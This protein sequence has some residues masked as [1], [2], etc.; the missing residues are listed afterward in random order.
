MS[1][2]VLIIS[3][4]CPS[5]DN[6][7]NGNFEFDQARALTAVGYEVIMLCVDR[8]RSAVNRKIGITVEN[9]DGILV[10]KI[11][12][13]PLPIR[14]FL[15]LTTLF[16]LIIGYFL[17]VRIKKDIGIPDIV[18]SHYLYNHPLAVLIGKKYNI[19]TILTEHW[20]VLNFAH[21]PFSVKFI[22]LKTYPY[23]SA[24]VAVSESLRNSIY[25]ISSVDSVVINNMVDVDYFSD[26]KISLPKDEDKFIFISVGSL[27]PV[28][29]YKLLIESFVDA[30]FSKDVYLYIVGYGIDY[31]NLLSIIK[32]YNI[33]NRVLLL[34]KKNRNEIRNLLLAADVFVLSSNSE[35]FGVVLIEAMACGLPVIS[36]KCGGPEEFVTEDVGCLVAKGDRFAL[37]ESMLYMFNFS[38]RFSPFLIRDY[39]KTKFSST[40]ISSQLDNLYKELLLYRNDK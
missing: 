32:K 35:T 28:K 33:E 4:G 17:F 36:T 9:V 14:F 5:D 23:A 31:D 6:P 38:K 22:A 21:I 40:V 15:L 37:K 1:T 7:M 16:S 19:P 13:F 3:R 25:R 26:R 18:H 8:R 12:L 24:V 30:G 34:G 10:Y 27:V 2:K 39:C 11:F 20:S 29:N